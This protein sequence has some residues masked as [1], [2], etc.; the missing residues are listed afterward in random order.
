MTINISNRLIDLSVYEGEDRIVSS[1]ELKEEL[2]ERYKNIVY[3][4]TGLPTLNELIGGFVDGELNVISGITKNGKTLLCQTLTN[5]FAKNKINSLWFTY[6]VPVMQFLF[7]FGEDLPHFYMPKVLKNRNLE[8]IYNR[9]KEAVLK[10]NIKMVFIDHLHYLADVMIQTNPSLEI[11]RVMR[12]LKTWA[13]NLNIS[14]FI[15]AHTG[16]VKPDK[17][18]DS[19]DTRDSSFVEQEADNIFYI[20]RSKNKENEAI[21]KITGNRGRGVMNRKITL[22][23]VGK[24]LVELAKTGVTDETIKE[25]KY[26]HHVMLWDGNG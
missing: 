25:V 2:K 14:I 17:E 4:Q 15:V 1:E 19:G 5:H 21:L 22:I 6:E 16:K 20:W 7:Q 11:G 23:K 8:W 18:L 12:T 9:I 26:K 13:V 3:H 10:F 24:Y